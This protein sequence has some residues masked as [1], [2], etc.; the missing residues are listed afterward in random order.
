VTPRKHVVLTGATGFIGSHLVQHL[1][2]N[3]DWLITGLDSLTYAGD[4]GR[5]V[6][7]GRF[8]PERVRLFWHDL[9]APVMPTLDRRIRSRGEV[10]YLVNVASA[11]HI[12]QSIADPV[13]FV[14]NNVAVGL[15]ALEYARVVRPQVFV[16]FETDEVY[17]ASQVPLPE[18]APIN[19]SNPYSAS[20]AG[21]AALAI[22]W[23][24]T[25][26]VPVVLVAPMNNFGE[27]Q[28]R[29]KFVP[30]VVRAVERGEVVTIH[31][32]PEAIGSRHY[33]HARNAA[34]AVLYLL[35]RAPTAYPQADRPDRY[36]VVGD[37][38]VDNLEMAQRIA[39]IVGRPLRWQFDHNPRA[40]PGHDLHYALDGGKLERLGWEA[41]VGFEASLERTVRWMVANPDW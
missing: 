9:R 24:R 1:L 39:A 29:E 28:D 26:G 7:G 27:R 31:G 12:D 10:D 41:P 18:W 3:T 2:D 16:Q 8:D 13:P 36:N 5:V 17:G 15:H 34:D 37:R 30:K 19:P 40:R 35:N 11:S 33:L 38:R 4:A 14:L 20:K 23:W 21:Q 32:S 6:E 25:Y 22:A